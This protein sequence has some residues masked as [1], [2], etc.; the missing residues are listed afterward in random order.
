MKP[1]YIAAYH[2]SDFGKLFALTIPQIVEK[3]VLEC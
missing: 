2:Q 3:A 1:L